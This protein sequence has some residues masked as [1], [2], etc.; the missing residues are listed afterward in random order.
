MKVCKDGNPTQLFSKSGVLTFNDEDGTLPLATKK[1]YEL[2]DRCIGSVFE[3]LSP[4][5]NIQL[6]DGYFVL[7]N[8]LDLVQDWSIA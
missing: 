1:E 8:E 5:E 4:E 2:A 6:Q 7:D 3:A